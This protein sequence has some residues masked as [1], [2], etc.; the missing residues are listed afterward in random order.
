MNPRLRPRSAL[1]LATALLLAPATLAQPGGGPPGGDRPGASGDN[2]L[3]F[4]QRTFQ[5]WVESGEAVI[6]VERFKGSA[7]EVS[8]SYSVVGGT[9]TAG[10][11][12][13]EVSGTLTWAD[14][15]TARKTFSI[16]IHDDDL[17]EVFETIELV[18]SEP[19]GGATLHP[20]HGQAVV[21]IRDA[22]EDNPGQVGDLDESPGTL[23]LVD[24]ELQGV[25]GDA[26]T[27]RVQ[28]LAAQ[29]F[30]I[31]FSEIRFEAIDPAKL[32]LPSE[33]QALRKD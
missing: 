4:D 32:T 15:D 14:G 31:T 10:V 27:V 33:I 28:R 29:E 18:L 19:T 21:M 11:D 23:R 17:F 7:G 22:R 8:V 24:A 9:A 20:G 3:K 12:Y 16:V 13:D 1:L 30:S 26:A 5:V 25:E 6:S 2:V